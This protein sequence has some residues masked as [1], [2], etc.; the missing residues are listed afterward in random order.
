MQADTGGIPDVVSHHRNGILVP[1][2]DAD[3][4][5]EAILEA[6][7]SEALRQRL[8][9]GSELTAATTLNWDAIARDLSHVFETA[10]PSRLGRAAR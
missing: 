2:G 5:A 7:T 10:A 1:P 4:L 9:S 6:A 8:R 3:A